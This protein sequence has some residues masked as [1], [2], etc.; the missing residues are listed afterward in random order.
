MRDVLMCYGAILWSGVRK[1]ICGARGADAEAIGFD[2][3]PKPK[4]WVAELKQRR[5]A[6]VRN[7]CREE[8]AAVIQEYKKRGGAIYNARK[9]S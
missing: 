1:V 2:E 6:V 8:A 9:R 7:L 4:N 5:I 3:G